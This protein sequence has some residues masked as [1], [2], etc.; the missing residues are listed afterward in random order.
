MTQQITLARDIEYLQRCNVH[1][2]ILNHLRRI[3][4][5]Q[6]LQQFTRLPEV[7]GTARCSL[8]RRGPTRLQ[9]RHDSVSQ[10]IAIETL[11]EIAVILDPTATAGL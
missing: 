11:I 10:V 6:S 8:R 1:H 7:R 4:V 9:Q 3:D 5:R 2:A